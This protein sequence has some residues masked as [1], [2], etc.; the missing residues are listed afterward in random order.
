FDGDRRAECM[1]VFGLVE[2]LRMD[3]RRDSRTFGLMP[4]RGNVGQSLR[5][6]R[7]RL[8]LR[9]CRLEQVLRDLE[10]AGAVVIARCLHATV[11]SARAQPDG[12]IEQLRGGR[13]CAAPAGLYC[14]R[15]EC[16]HGRVVR[17]DCGEREVARPFF[18]ALDECAELPVQRAPTAWL[19]VRIDAF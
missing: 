11:D 7:A 19:S 16:G 4:D 8:Q 5:A 3:L 18:D 17:C 6:E 1:I 9:D 10:L 12:E 15:I 14:S 2:R 13:G